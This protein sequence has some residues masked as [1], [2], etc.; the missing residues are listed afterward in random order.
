VAF[1]ADPHAGGEGVRFGNF[2]NRL[3][4]VVPL[5]VT[6]LV[7]SAIGADGFNGA[8][9]ISRAIIARMMALVKPARSARRG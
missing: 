3:Q 9:P 5:D 7:S 4:D 1:A 2:F 6:E 8:E